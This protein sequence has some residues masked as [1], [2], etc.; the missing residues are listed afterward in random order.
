MALFGILDTLVLAISERTRE[1]GLLRAV[2]MTR[3]QLRRMVR[4]E[5][6][7]TS[8]VGTTIGALF[9]VAVAYAVT[10]PVLEGTFTVPWLELAVTAVAGVAIGVLASIF[11]AWRAARQDPLDAIRSG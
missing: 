8:M 9:G 5:A 4:T 6:L 7:V 3:A 1:L 2:G 10:R 11:P